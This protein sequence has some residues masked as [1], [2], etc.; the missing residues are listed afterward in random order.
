MRVRERLLVHRDDLT[1][2]GTCDTNHRRL[3]AVGC[4]LTL[5]IS[6]SGQAQESSRG[7][8]ERPTGAQPSLSKTFTPAVIGVG[9]VSLVTITLTNPN[10]TVAMLTGELDDTLPESLVITTGFV[11]SATTCP[12]GHVSALNGFPVFSLNLG[13]QI[14]AQG[15]CTVT[16]C[17]ITDTAGD[18]TNTLS[19]SALQTNL[20]NNINP[21]SAVVTA[22]PD[23]VFASAFDNPCG[24]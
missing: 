9:G 6:V 23:F 19:A 17:V 3:A 11:D 2:K 7:R 22:T 4:L 10:T 20:G 1:M 14:P 8:T 12:N 21:A 15:S 16:A 24:S 5:V 18:Y 13:A